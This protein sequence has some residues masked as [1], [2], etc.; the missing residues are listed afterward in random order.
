MEP[1]ESEHNETKQ[2]ETE[3]KETERNEIEQKVTEQD[4]TEPQVLEQNEM[5]PRNTSTVTPCSHGLLCGLR[6][7]CAAGAGLAAVWQP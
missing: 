5:E 1:K 2:N 4:E 3:P 7:R 6:P